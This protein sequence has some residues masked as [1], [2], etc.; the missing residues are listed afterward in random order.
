MKPLILILFLVQFLKSYSQ[1]SDEINLEDLKT[2][3]SPGFQILDISP[4]SIERPA[5]PKEF[6]L[7]ALNISNNASAIPKNFAL[8]MSPYWYFKPANANVYKYLNLKYVDPSTRQVHNYVAAGILNK[9]SLSIASSFSDSTSGSLLANTNYISFG[10]RTN[11]L[12]IRSKKQNDDFSNL[13]TAMSV[14]VGEVRK[15]LNAQQIPWKN[16]SNILK[17]TLD[18]VTDGL[19]S[20]SDTQ[21][22]NKEIADL[23]D[24]IKSF[25]KNFANN[26]EKTLDTDDKY[27]VFKQSAE[28]FTGDELP[29]FQLDAAYAYSEALPDNQYSGRRFNRS[30]LWFNATLSTTLLKQKQDH[31]SFIFL[32]RLINDN[33]LTDT[34]KNN[35]EKENAIDAGGKIDY[36][37]GRFSI[38]FESLK[39]SYSNNT[40]LSSIRTVGIVQY[41]IND[42][43]YIT[44]TYG[45]NF[46]DTNNLFALLG[47]NWGFGNSPLSI[48][49]H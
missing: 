9:L 38:A 20:G 42:N 22:I 33:V 32:F 26:L 18:S 7:S 2:P 48:N 37:I 1:K 43:L 13:V 30:G 45:K 41:K 19:R 16:R 8:E 47:L 39:R 36:T 28:N 21:Q 3:N 15:A 5:S 4:S 24:S 29:L 49:N 12:T 34:S 25:Q 46:G 23:N 31:L 10:A 6:A 40:D 11:L 17:S 14:R 35:F 44:G 27:M